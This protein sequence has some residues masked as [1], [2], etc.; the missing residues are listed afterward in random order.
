[1]THRRAV[2]FAPTSLTMRMNAANRKVANNLL[3]ALPGESYR[4]L[5]SGWAQ[6]NSA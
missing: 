3:A 5:R 1:M 6:A 2:L 4:R